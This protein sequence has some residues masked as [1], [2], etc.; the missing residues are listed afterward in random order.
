MQ[1][2]EE[3][4]EILS[5]EDGS[6]NDA[7]IK[8]KVLLH[9]LGEKRL[10]EWVNLELQ[11][12]TD[13]ETLPEYRKIPMTIMGDFNNGVY[14]HS[15]QVLP[16][17]HL[18]EPLRTNLAKTNLMQSV[19]VLE[20]YA[21]EDKNLAVSLMPEIYH[22]LSEGLGNGY[23]VERAWGKHSVGGIVQVVTEVKSRLLD[24]V[25]ELSDRMPD[26]L[27]RQEM[28]VASQQKNVSELFNHTV[29]GDNAT[30]VIG[31]NNVQHVENRIT[32]NDFES[33]ASE[34]A[35]HKMPAE[36]IEELRLAIE[37]DEGAE[38]HKEKSF[39]KNVNAWAGKMLDKAA[40]SSWAI[41]I[42]AAGSLVATAV[43]AYYGF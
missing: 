14:R 33:L 7:L 13:P 11:G 17:M 6:L 43:R 38:E 32:V 4:I 18:K 23:E 2:I 36:D 8:T 29:I 28:K 9:R 30:F 37:A 16:T 22:L 1:I 35:R 3:I 21:E 34:L 15:N 20:G 12:Y 40:T 10:V 42:G 25:L 27:D 39:G 19:A 24:F 31:D 41:G 5:S 26:E